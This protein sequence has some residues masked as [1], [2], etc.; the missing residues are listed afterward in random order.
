MERLRTSRGTWE[1]KKPESEAVVGDLVKFTV[2]SR[3]YTV[4]AHDTEDGDTIGREVL[5]MKVG[6]T[7]KSL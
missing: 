3:D 4:L 5:G 6:E 2:E 1:D 7:K